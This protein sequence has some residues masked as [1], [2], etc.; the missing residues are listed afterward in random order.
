[1]MELPLARMNASIRE[2]V[3]EITARMEMMNA[4][5]VIM[6]A[7]LKEMREEIKSGQAEMRSIVEAIIDEMDAWQK[8]TMACQETTEAH[9]K[10]KEPT[11]EAMEA[12]QEKVPKEHAEMIP[13]KRTE[14]V[15]WRLESGQGAK[16]EERGKLCIL[17]ET[18][19]RWQKDNPQCQSD[20]EERERI[21]DCTRS[22]VVQEIW[23]GRTLGGRCQLK[24]E[25]RKSI[26]RQDVE[27]LLHLRKWR[28]PPTVSEERAEDSSHDW[29]V[30][31]IDWTLWKGQSLPKRKQ[32]L[33]L[34]CE[35]VM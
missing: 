26:R 30:R 13:V 16:H 19:C 1:M 32:K 18:D 22:N 7:N 31:E 5:Q 3:Q 23:R 6:N 11:S 2:H 8:V 29:K 25:C 28:K 9:L 10:C 15:A 17:E 24:L 35:L 34:E 12:E 4:N 14:E 20:M 27:E 21:K 33:Q